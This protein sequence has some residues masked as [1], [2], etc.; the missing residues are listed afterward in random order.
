MPSLEVHCAE[1]KAKLGKEYTEV[2]LWLD[3][4]FKTMG[5]AHRDKRHHE[6]GVEEARKLR[7]GLPNCT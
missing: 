1:C 5:P 7:G 3:E 6:G 4:F 2:H